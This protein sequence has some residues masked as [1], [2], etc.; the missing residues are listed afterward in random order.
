MNLPTTLE[1][2]AE[3]LAVLD[4]QIEMLQDRLIRESQRE[5]HAPLADLEQTLN[6]LTGSRDVLR[7]H[8]AAVQR[9]WP[10]IGTA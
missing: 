8:L 5:G 3:R 2:I 6:T 1:V 9:Q 7:D 4:H 10:Q